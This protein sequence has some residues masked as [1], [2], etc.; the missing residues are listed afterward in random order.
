[1][2]GSPDSARRSIEL[3]ASA[4]RRPS[5]VSVWSTSQ[6]TPRIAGRTPAGISARG[7]TTIDVY[8]SHGS[9]LLAADF[10]A[11]RR[12]GLGDVAE[13][14]WNVA[15]GDGLDRDARALILEPQRHRRALLERLHC[16]V[17]RIIRQRL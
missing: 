1:M 7:S 10:L 15:R 14:A 9:R 2:T 8:T 4:V 13:P 12:L 5:V 3:Y 16:L 11:P 17:D 6:S